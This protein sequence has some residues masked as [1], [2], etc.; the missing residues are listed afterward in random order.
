M[1]KFIDKFGEWLRHKVCVIIIKQW[2]ISKKI[3]KSFQLLNKKSPYQFRDEQSIE[4]QT[5][6]LASTNEQQ[7]MSLTFY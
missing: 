6:D 2:K 5:H 4:Q 1:K 3:E 7:E